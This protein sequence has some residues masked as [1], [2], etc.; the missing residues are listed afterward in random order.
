[1]DK[2]DDIIVTLVLLESMGFLEKEMVFG[3]SGDDGSGG[4]DCC[5]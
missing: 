3:N 5:D 1:M 2:I 4:N